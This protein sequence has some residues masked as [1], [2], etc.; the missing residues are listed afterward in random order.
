MS[1]TE[2]VLSQLLHWIATALLAAAVFWAYRWMRRQSV[3]LATVFGIG[4]ICR[5][6]FGLA[7]FAVSYLDLPLASGLHF[8]DGFWE[9]ASDARTYYRS[10][11]HAHEA[12]LSVIASSAGSPAYVKTLALWMHVVG[13]SP[14]VGLF[15]NLV[16]FTALSML[17]VQVWGPRG[18]VKGDL[19]CMV[20]IAGFAFSPAIAI[21]GSQ[22]MKEDLF[23][24]LIAVT[25]VAVLRLYE[26]RT[27]RGWPVDLAACL[28]VAGAVF[29]VA[30]IRS[31][32]GLMLWG[33]LVAGFVAAVA[34]V[35]PRNSLRIVVLGALSL[36][37]A[38][39]GYRVASGT[40][41]WNPIDVPA[42]V[43][44]VPAPTPVPQPPAPATPTPSPSP[45]K[46]TRPGEPASPPAA[47]PETPA[48]A[49]AHTPEPAPGPSA[50][51][52]VTTTMANASDAAALR[53]RN[54]RIGFERSGGATN[55]VI[56]R[57]GSGLLAEGRVLL[58][59]LVTML[60]PITLLKAVGAI[61]FEGG[62]SLLL[63]TDLDTLFLDLTLVATF[64]FLV[65]NWRIA[66]T[67]MPYLVFM[68][69]L[70][71]VTMFLL[72]YVVT[73]YGTLF[74]LRAMAAGPLWLLVLA[75]RRRS[76]PVPPPHETTD[77]A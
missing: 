48:P 55:V 52:A 53:L 77:V 31:Y 60:V 66:R 10:A 74:R 25:G 41:Y 24:F 2:L 9:L 16:I 69:G 68:G 54:A 70:G 33:A 1:N 38:W 29:M 17:L 64:V 23:L 45:S 30:G 19:P 39:G 62:R 27:W 6:L 72:A 58:F 7:L 28:L 14:A 37:L 12:G 65:R 57:K 26:R 20:A 21:H 56:E 18:T 5:A 35:G 42:V 73:N 61:E 75:L 76:E 63:L 44:P 32:F 22:S 3:P 67:Q 15:L 59:G 36:S 11:L 13:T 47:V 34:H 49:P 43:T 50:V 8:G 46:H 40:Y 4:L 51:A 71:L